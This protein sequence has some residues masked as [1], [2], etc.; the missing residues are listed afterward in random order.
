MPPAAETRIRQPHAA[1]YREALQPGPEVQVPGTPQTAAP[2]SGL[3]ALALLTAD[4]LVW[5]G[6]FS[7]FLGLLH[8]FSN[9]SSL[10]NA[11]VLGIPLGVS[12]LSSWLVGAYDRDND[13]RSLRFAS[14]FL[15][16]GFFAAIVGAG[17]VAL[18]GSYG[19]TQLASRFLLLAT[20]LAYTLVTLYG[21][22][23]LAGRSGWYSN[24]LRC[25]LLIGSPEEAAALQRALELA[26]RPATV[27]HLDPASASSDNLL[28][29][30]TAPASPDPA[31]PGSLPL[32][33]IV[34]G[35]S[36]SPLPTGLSPLLVSIHTTRLPVYNW[37]AFWRQRVRM[38]DVHDP[39]T[40][41]LFERDFR[42]TTISVY[43]H[44]KRLVDIVLA[45]TALLLTAPI[46]LLAGI[47][48]RLD[49]P[50][51]ALFRQQRIGFRGKPFVIY[52]FRSMRVNSEAAGTTT[53]PG[54]SRI[55]RLGHF[56]RRSRIDEIPQL[57]NVLKG[58]MSFVG[59]RPEWTV[60][61]DLYEQQ[62][63][64]YHLRHLAKPGITGWAQVNYPYGQDVYDARNKLSFD[65]YYVTH[66]SLILDCTILLKTFY[67]VLGRIGGQ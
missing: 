47:A 32:G 25:V 61:V 24:G 23:L 14:E 64:Y 35:P 44:V 6:I 46:L 20:P 2:R 41:W 26:G 1:S 60:C 42:L 40:A 49:S 54:D 38:H 19:S 10:P 51:P 65:L 5:I 16:A 9:G 45:A 36:A 58:D 8:L 53:T 15:I 34:L 18:F 29:R 13:F 48:V 3:L 22:R 33:A 50:G 67:V 62:L 66:A 12:L 31:R 4:T 43:W 56:L 37:P 30:V 52:K 39:A 59:P 28:T 7:A 27:E 11:S 17:L 55:T 63:P 57:I 21:R